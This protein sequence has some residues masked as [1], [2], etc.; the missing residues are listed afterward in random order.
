[1]TARETADNLNFIIIHLR[2]K[3]HTLSVMTIDNNGRK[4]H[5]RSEKRWCPNAGEVSLH[6]QNMGIPL[7]Y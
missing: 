6:S 2:V 7:V 3:W 5:K 1:M 4:N